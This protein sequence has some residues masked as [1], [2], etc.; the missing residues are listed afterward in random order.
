MVN[1]ESTI[2]NVLKGI[3]MIEQGINKKKTSEI[4]SFVK[5]SL[6]LP[7]LL[8][9][10]ILVQKNWDTE[11]RE[12][13]I[14]AYVRLFSQI[15]MGCYYYEGRYFIDVHWIEGFLKGNRWK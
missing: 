6:D 5:D 15:G 12:Q 14:N 13:R 1:D 10:A 7:S 11:N 2:E 9:Q 8:E 3:Q 4:E